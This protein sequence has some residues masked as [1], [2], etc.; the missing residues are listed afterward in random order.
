MKV[1]P[2][3]IDLNQYVS[4]DSVVDYN[5]P[6]IINLAEKIWKQANTQI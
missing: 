3:V 1:K 2:S 4:C 6:E 5:N